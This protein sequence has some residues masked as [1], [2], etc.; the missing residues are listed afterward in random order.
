MHNQLPDE[1]Q[2]GGEFVGIFV[3]MY[4]AVFRPLGRE[5]RKRRQLKR[6]E[7]IL[8]RGRAA[9]KGISAAVLPLGERLES[10]ENTMATQDDIRGIVA[11]Q[12]HQAEVTGDLAAAVKDLQSSYARGLERVTTGIE[13][14]ITRTEDV[15]AT[16]SGNGS[17][18]HNEREG[19]S[20][21]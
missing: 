12:R 13:T 16:L 5:A 20:E 18:E 4:G 8:M 17:R 21:T 3:A 2:S 19:D 15:A 10:I 11:G 7:K 9:I 1:L 14:A 6:E